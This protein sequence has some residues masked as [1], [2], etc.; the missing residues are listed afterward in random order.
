[1][2]PVLEFLTGSFRLD[3]ID[4]TAEVNPFFESAAF[5]LFNSASKVYN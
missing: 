4:N 5:F 2:Y 3:G 1:M